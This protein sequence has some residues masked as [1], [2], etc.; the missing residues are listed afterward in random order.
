MRRIVPQR[1]QHLWYIYFG[2]FLHLVYGTI[3]DLRMAAKP[4]TYLNH[5]FHIGS[6]TTVPRV[7]NRNATRGMTGPCAAHFSCSTQSGHRHDGMLPQP[8]NA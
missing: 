2:N 4:S 8:A 5:S 6:C 3:D 1:R 7:M